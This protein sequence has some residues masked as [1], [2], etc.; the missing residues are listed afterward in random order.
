MKDPITDRAKNIPSFI[1]MDVI[2]RAVAMQKAGEDV[3]VLAVGEPDFPTPQVIVQAAEKALR[4]GKTK[5]TH[6][7]GIPDL[8]EAIARDYYNRYKVRVSP[9]QIIITPGTSPA[10]FLTFSSI[11]D[12]GDEIIVSDPAYACYKNMIEYLHGK[13][14]TVPVYEETGFQLEPEA[15]EEKITNRTKGIMINSPANP[16]GLNSG[17]GP[18]EKNRRPGAAGDLG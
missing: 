1:V 7:L 5:Y 10:M 17:P 11:L 14:T 6:S 12:V 16:T 15:V 8:R 2:D 3:V 18:D 4:E 13:A 9:D